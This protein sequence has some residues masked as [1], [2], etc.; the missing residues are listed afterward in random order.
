MVERL[1]Y[2]SSNTMDIS[3]KWFKYFQL[4]LHMK[5][6]IPLDVFRALPGCWFQ[7]DPATTNLESEVPQLLTTTGENFSSCHTESHHRIISGKSI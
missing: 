7:S 4:E 2:L 3:I 5:I 6:K 1:H